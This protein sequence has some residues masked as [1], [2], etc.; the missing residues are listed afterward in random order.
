MQ[1]KTHFE[2]IEIINKL[3]EM[4]KELIAVNAEKENMILALMKESD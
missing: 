4:I 1:E 3:N 2:L